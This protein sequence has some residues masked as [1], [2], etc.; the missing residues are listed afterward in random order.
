LASAAPEAA[1]VE[2]AAEA[3]K[4]A[5]RPLPTHLPREEVRHRAAHACPSC[6]GVLRRI[7]EDVTETR[8]RAG[9]L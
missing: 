1:I 9:P 3:Q 8:L 2:G 4:P 7:G 5:R 6:G